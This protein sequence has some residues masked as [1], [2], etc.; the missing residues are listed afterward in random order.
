MTDT[1]AKML[2]I[3]LMDRDPML[4]A[5]MY[6]HGKEWRPDL[7]PSLEIT[8]DDARKLPGITIRSLE[9]SLEWPNGPAKRAVYRSRWV[10]DTRYGDKAGWRSEFHMGSIPEV[11]ASALIGKPLSN[12]IN[13]EGA[14][15]WR[16]QS[17]DVVPGIATKMVLERIIDVV[18]RKDQTD[19]RH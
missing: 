15:K 13:A 17:V 9:H 4:A 6:A 11:I 14:D 1:Y 5:A 8:R 12:V 18:D 10:D 3:R 7:K 2:D 16:I 19:A